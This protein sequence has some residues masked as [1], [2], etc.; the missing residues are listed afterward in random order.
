MANFDPPPAKLKVT[1]SLQ[2]PPH[3]PEVSMLFALTP[4][5]SS[6]IRLLRV[7]RNIEYGGQ[8][9]YEKVTLVLQGVGVTRLCVVLNF[10]LA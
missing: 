5:R 2:L 7:G 1:L 9:G 4:P 6:H 3:T 10:L 8:G